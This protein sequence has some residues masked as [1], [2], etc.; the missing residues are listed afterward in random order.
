MGGAVPV[1]RAYTTIGGLSMVPQVMTVITLVIP[2]KVIPRMLN[3]DI[4]PCFPKK[5]QQNYPIK[6]PTFD[7]KILFKKSRIY[8]IEP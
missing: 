5:K 3:P 7:G 4:I 6:I 2:I 8:H 1:I